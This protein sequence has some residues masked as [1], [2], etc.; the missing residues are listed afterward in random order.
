MKLRL[1]LDSL[2]DKELFSKVVELLGS[3]VE[4]VVIR[5]EVKY[6]EPVKKP[7]NRKGPVK[8]EVKETNISL[9]EITS[10]A[11]EMINKVG[12]PAVIEVINLYGAKLSAVESKD[13]DELYEKLSNLEGI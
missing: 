2:E 9:A 3:K 12:K 10:L 5:E 8:K 6:E 7:V 1:E 13:Y 4:T 11:K